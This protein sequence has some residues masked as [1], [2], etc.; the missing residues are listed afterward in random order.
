[1]VLLCSN[2]HAAQ[3]RE[4]PATPHLHGED[5]DLVRGDATFRHVQGTD[6]VEASNILGDFIGIIAGEDDLD[7]PPDPTS[8]PSEGRKAV[9]NP[10]HPRR[11]HGI[12]GPLLP[13]AEF[14]CEV[15]EV[16]VMGPA[17][18]YGE[19]VADLEPHGAGLAE[20]QMVR[21]RGISPQTGLGCEATN[22]RWALSRCRR[23]SLIV[24]TLL[25]ILVGTVSV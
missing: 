13:P 3:A 14:I 1:L 8:D 15:M 11:G 24:R 12:Y 25:S 19:L 5:E 18:G 23:G 2:S 10:E 22:L 20:P 4:K 7:A 9:Q 21:V 17:Q 6:I 16:A